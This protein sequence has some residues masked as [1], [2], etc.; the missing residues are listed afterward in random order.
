MKKF[1]SVLLVCLFVC[2]MIAPASAQEIVQNADSE[3]IV[4]ENNGGRAATVPTEKTQLPYDAKTTGLQEG[5]TTLT[6][7]YFAPNYGQT[8]L[9]VSGTVTPSGDKNNTSRYAEIYL[10]K[11]GSNEM[12]DN[13]TIPQFAA[14]TNFSC[15]FIGLS[16]NS[17]YYIA[18]KNTTSGMFWDSFYIDASFTI[19]S[20]K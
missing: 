15:E 4:V 10:Y 8:K 2:G 12:V 14:T 16:S 20:A 19:S 5:T 6:K 7:Y 13:Y 9:V 3:M 17:N 1:M 11:V 18:F